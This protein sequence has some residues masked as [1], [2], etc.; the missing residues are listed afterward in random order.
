MPK[1]PRSLFSFSLLTRYLFSWCVC[2]LC[3]VLFRSGYRQHSRIQYEGYQIYS[4]R[5]FI[6]SLQMR[7]SLLDAHL[8]FGTSFG[9][10]GSREGGVSELLWQC[11]TA[12]ISSA[13]TEGLNT[14]HHPVGWY[15]DPR[16][17]L[18]SQQMKTVTHKLGDI[19]AVTAR[20]TE[21]IYW[22]P[23]RATCRRSSHL[24]H[25]TLILK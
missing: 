8:D 9:P 19:K 14:P 25:C 15:V 23:R 22:H 7:L 5:L 17:S 20:R 3:A 1:Q 12:N 18:Q 13:L 11:S 10:D 16:L 24:F 21:L 2:M 4:N 6:A